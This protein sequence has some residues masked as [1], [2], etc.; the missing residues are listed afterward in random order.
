MKN[1]QLLFLCAL[2]TNTC[3]PTLKANF[4]A[5][6]LFWIGLKDI[7]ETEKNE[8]LKDRDVACAQ[9]DRDQD[10]IMHY[11]VDYGEIRQ[12][13]RNAFNAIFSTAYHITADQAD[14]QRAREKASNE[15]IYL[16]QTQYQDLSEAHLKAMARDLA[17][18]A[19]L[20]FVSDRSEQL[21][22]HELTRM[23]KQPPVNPEYLVSEIKKE[24]IQEASRQLSERLSLQDFAGQGLRNK[25]NAKVRNAFAA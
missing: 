21:I 19:A 17:Y 22:R 7:P 24:M 4:G 3:C 1:L 16:L 12:E 5:R 9:A 20:Q 2:L 13:F 14:I 10:Q 23:H 8:A 15:A 11:R 6:I 25:I 18:S